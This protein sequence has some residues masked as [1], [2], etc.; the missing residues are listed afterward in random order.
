MLESKVE[1]GFYGDYNITG[2]AEF[3]ICI[4]GKYCPYATA[5]SKVRQLD[6]LRNYFCP[7]G[8]AG[9]LGVTG[10]FEEE[11]LH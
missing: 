2:K 5:A 4:P 1:S 11:T 10:D 7:M 9:E 6:C 8:T 3:F